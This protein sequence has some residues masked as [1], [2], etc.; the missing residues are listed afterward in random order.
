MKKALLSVTVL[1]ISSLA[2]FA[3]T[4]EKAVNN[5]IALLKKN[6]N[7]IK[8]EERE[9]RKE[10]RQIGNSQA[11]YLT[12][13][14]FKV[15]F[16]K[17]KIVRSGQEP[18]FDRVVYKE[19]GTEHDALYDFQG[20]L[21]GITTEK[22]FSD[23]PATARQFINKKFPGYKKDLVLLYDDNEENDTPPLLYEESYTGPDSYFVELN[24][25]GKAIV[26]QVDMGGTVSFFA[27]IHTS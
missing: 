18:G 9:D 6:E 2:L 17:A 7:R 24:R 12:L 22:S 1:M 11:G 20:M 23:L 8:K 5:D 15:D 16:P 13:E 4:Q 26:L 27:N 14:N 21:I 10:L 25:D 3:Q 19:N